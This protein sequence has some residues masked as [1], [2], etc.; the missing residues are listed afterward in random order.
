MNQI[1]DFLPWARASFV[2]GMSPRDLEETWHTEYLCP[3]ML[4]RVYRIVLMEAL[5]PAIHD[6]KVICSDKQAELYRVDGTPVPVYGSADVPLQ[7]WKP[8]RRS[9]GKPMYN[10]VVHHENPTEI[11]TNLTGVPND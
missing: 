4:K 3:T 10:Y 8:D 2:L 6:Q 11:F 1:T 5:I 7:Y 9:C